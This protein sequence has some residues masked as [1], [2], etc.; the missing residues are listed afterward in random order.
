MGQAKK[1]E[2]VGEE[3]RG[4]MNGELTVDYTTTVGITVCGMV[5]GP[6]AQV[7][8]LVHRQVPLVA[9]VQHTVGVH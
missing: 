1:T 3:K 9:R 7:I 5:D 4:N 2:G 6:L 8:G